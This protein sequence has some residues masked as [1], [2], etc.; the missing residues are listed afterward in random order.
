MCARQ[1]PHLIDL[2]KRVDASKRPARRLQLGVVLGVMEGARMR[3]AIIAGE[4]QVVTRVNCPMAGVAAGAAVVVTPLGRGG[5]AAEVVT[6][7]GREG[8]PQPIEMVGGH[9]DRCGQLRDLRLAELEDKLG[10]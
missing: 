7:L 9:T 2:T 3:L 4:A 10:P 6:P 8:S 5:Y 1:T